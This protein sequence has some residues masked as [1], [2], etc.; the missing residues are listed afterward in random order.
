MPAMKLAVWIAE[1]GHPKW[2]VADLIGINASSL[3]RYL[4]GGQVPRTKLIRRIERITGGKV[5]AADW[6]AVDPL[7]DD[8]EARP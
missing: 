7:Q 2:L 6:F 3:S 8:G 5:T 4:R 1:A